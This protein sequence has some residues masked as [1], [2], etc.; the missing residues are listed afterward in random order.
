[1]SN[2]F[3]WVSTL[4]R[5]SGGWVCFGTVVCLDESSMWGWCDHP[6][7]RPIVREEIANLQH[8][9]SLFSGRGICSALTNAFEP[10]RAALKLQTEATGFRWAW[11]KSKH[12]GVVLMNSRS[13]ESLTHPESQGTDWTSSRHCVL[14]SGCVAALLHGMMLYKHEAGEPMTN[15]SPFPGFPQALPWEGKCGIWPHMAGCRSCCNIFP[16]RLPPTVWR[17]SS[18]A[19]WYCS[20]AKVQGQDFLV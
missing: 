9:L 13:D 7:D 5:K 2:L 1:M 14:G 16:A 3:I 4:V 12:E 15:P 20:A 18:I 11:T 6:R 19:L 8:V 17:S 10:Q